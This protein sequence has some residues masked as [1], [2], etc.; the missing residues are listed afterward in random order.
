MNIV[1][2]SIQKKR[3]FNKSYSNVWLKTLAL[4][5]HKVTPK[6]GKILRGIAKKEE[7]RWLFI[8]IYEALSHTYGRIVIVF[9]L[10]LYRE[11]IMEKCALNLQTDNRRIDRRR[12]QFILEG[13]LICDAR[14][15]KRKYL[16]KKNY[17][18]LKRW[19]R[20]NDTDYVIEWI[21][22]I[23]HHFYAECLMKIRQC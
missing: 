2:I 14:N 5:S 15:K 6:R 20:D 10:N 19:S 11:M 21:A 23:F 22:H 4:N 8:E 12:S 13:K 3:F 17:L 16:I 9:H 7:N 18:W 1:D